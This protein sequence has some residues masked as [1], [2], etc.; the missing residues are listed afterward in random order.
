MTGKRQTC[1]EAVEGGLPFK[2]PS[3]VTE[4]A[5]RTAD[6]PLET[7]GSYAVLSYPVDVRNPLPVASITLAEED[8][9]WRVD[10]ASFKTG[11]FEPPRVPRSVRQQL[12]GLDGG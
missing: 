10:D 11:A 9:A 12:E 2:D 7:E 6:V 1:E 8:G 3:A 5:E 4:A